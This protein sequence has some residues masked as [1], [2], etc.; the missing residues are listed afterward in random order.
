MSI[1]T[2][3][4]ASDSPA[5]LPVPVPASEDRSVVRGLWDVFRREPML[6][7]TCSY[8][9]VS[10]VG[11]IDSYWFYRRFEIPIL[12]YMQSSDYFVA[13]LRS[14]QYL[15]LLAGLI[16]MSAIALL[17]DRWR[18]RHPQR[19]ERLQSRWWGRM[20]VPKRNDWWAYFGLHPETMATILSLFV[21]VTLLFSHSNFRATDIQRGGTGGVEFRLAGEPQPVPGAWRMLGTS[22]AFVFL[23]NIDERRAEV[24]PIEAIVGIRP[25]RRDQPGPV[26]HDAPESG[27]GG[28]PSR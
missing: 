16:T 19:A 15:T 12:E 2:E 13:G 10:I 23:W 5:D 21:M 26:D 11:L 20:L 6:L 28:A 3:Q 27:A 17:P 7:V 18:Q 24:V 1:P 8:V 14:P 4:P 22:S 9:F 25:A